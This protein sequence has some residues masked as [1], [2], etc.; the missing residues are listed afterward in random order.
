MFNSDVYCV[1]KALNTFFTF[2]FLD[3]TGGK[4]V[5]SASILDVGVEQALNFSGFDEKM[6]FQRGG[7]Y[8]WSKKD[9]EMEW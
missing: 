6:F 4:K 2:R 7:R 1:H 9:R 3:N 5:P 8:V